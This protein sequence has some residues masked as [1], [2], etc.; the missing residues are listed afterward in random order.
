M[1]SN[2]CQTIKI[3]P[4]EHLVRGIKSELD[5]DNIEYEAPNILIHKNSK[6][7]D[8]PE[9]FEGNA[10]PLDLQEF[11][12]HFCPKCNSEFIGVVETKITLP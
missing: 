10:D 4:N 2:E 7:Q 5:E 3:E 6:R 8:D 11:T 1:D 9:F 12:S